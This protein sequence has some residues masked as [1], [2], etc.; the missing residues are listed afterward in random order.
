MFTNTEKS[1]GYARAEL[2]LGYQG[3][4]RWVGA[5]TQQPPVTP[6]LRGGRRGG[7]MVAVLWA[8][9]LD[10]EDVDAGAALGLALG[11]AV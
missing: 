1:G 6:G 2:Q 11:A 10:F 9:W 5:T 3:T 7:G 4:T 8:A